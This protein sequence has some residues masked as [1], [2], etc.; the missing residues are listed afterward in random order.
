MVTQDTS[1][2]LCSGRHN[3]YLFGRT[4]TGG[5]GQVTTK[6]RRKAPGAL[7]SPQG[8]KYI[9]VTQDTSPSSV[10]EVCDEYLFGQAKTG[11]LIDSVLMAG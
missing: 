3:E 6:K 2:N 11:S 10:A 7:A 4:K 9:M 1:P 8:A 5:L